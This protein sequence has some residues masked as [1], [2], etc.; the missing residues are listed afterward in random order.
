[1]FV[2][3]SQVIFII[4][5]LAALGAAVP[6]TQKQASGGLKQGD[7]VTSGLPADVQKAVDAGKADCRLNSN[8][9]AVCSD[10]SGA[11]GVFKVS[12]GTGAAGGG[13]AKVQAAADPGDGCP[14]PATKPKAKAAKTG[15]K[16]GGGDAGAGGGEDAKSP[17]L[18]QGDV[19][20]TG[21]PKSVQ[22]E[23]DAGR[24]DCRVNSNIQI[25]CSDQSGAN[26]IVGVD[27]PLDK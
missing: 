14:T 21:L 27:I 26:G 8:L 6:A 19:V 10:A 7:P 16:N 3:K 25:V 12:A 5:H 11:T 9:D 15:K 4:A 17:N 20:K 13:R 18:Q 1:M 24:A 2:S 23:V 22:K